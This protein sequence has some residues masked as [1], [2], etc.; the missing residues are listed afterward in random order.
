MRANGF[1]LRG[2][3][4][5]FNLYRLTLLEGTSHLRT[6]GSGGGFDLGVHGGGS[7]HRA[8][9]LCPGRATRWAK[10]THEAP[11]DQG[12]G[13]PELPDFM[14]F[15]NWQEL[16]PGLGLMGSGFP[17]TDGDAGAWPRAFCLGWLVFR[18]RA[19]VYLSIITRC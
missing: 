14:V 16:V 15:L 3:P 9:G 18:S 4:A 10:C 7:H 12:D 2:V 5:Y 19:G 6:V 8:S 11:G 17:C 13:N 1:I